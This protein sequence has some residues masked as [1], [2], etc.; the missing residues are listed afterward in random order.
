MKKVLVVEDDVYLCGAYKLKLSK[1]GF[2]VKTAGDGEEALAILRDF[3][4]DLILLDLIMPRKDGFETL[5][6]LKKNPV[7]KDIPVL[8]ATNLSQKEDIDKAISLGASDCVV[9]T[10]TSMDDFVLKVK[11]VLKLD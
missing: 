9:K 1:L 5:E 4:P 7:W 10:D 6:T 11:S 8:V 2:E 3:Q